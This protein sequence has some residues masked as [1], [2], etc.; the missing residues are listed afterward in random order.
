MK[1]KILFLFAPALM[2]AGCGK[3]AADA[4]VAVSASGTAAPADPNMPDSFG[5]AKICADGTKIYLLTGGAASGQYAVWD[6]AGKGSWELLAT[7]STPDSVCS[8]QRAGY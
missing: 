5:V 2:L 7:G 6:T 8:T 4:S 3:P 1:T